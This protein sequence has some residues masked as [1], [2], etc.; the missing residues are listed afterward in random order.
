MKK[1]VRKMGNSYVI[2]LNQEDRKIHNLKEGDIVDLGDVV[3][4]NKKRGKK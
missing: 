3:K 1:I 4:V 2:I